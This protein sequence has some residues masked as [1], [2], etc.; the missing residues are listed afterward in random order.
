VASPLKP[1]EADEPWT[2]ESWLK[3]KKDKVSGVCAMRLNTNISRRRFLAGVA[4][5]SVITGC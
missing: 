1:N 3:P 4:A 2:T 5:A